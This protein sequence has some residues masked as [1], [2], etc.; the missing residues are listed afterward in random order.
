MVGSG[1]LHVT[2][3]RSTGLRW[4]QQQRHGSATRSKRRGQHMMGS[5]R[6]QA[7]REASERAGAER[8]TTWHGGG[9]TQRDFAGAAGGEGIDGS[10]DGQHLVLEAAGQANRRSCCGWRWK[11]LDATT[12][13]KVREVLVFK[14]KGGVRTGKTCALRWMVTPAE[15]KFGSSPDYAKIC[16]AKPQKPARRKQQRCHCQVTP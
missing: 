1:Q 12:G 15:S 2:C 3:K 10:P 13:S 14:S 7:Q 4:T 6:P 5:D 16:Q 8:G 11:D 9:S